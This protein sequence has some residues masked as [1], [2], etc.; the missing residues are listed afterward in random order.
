MEAKPQGKDRRLCDE[1]LKLTLDG[2]KKCKRIDGNKVVYDHETNTLFCPSLG[3][4]PYGG[5]HPAT[6]FSCN[7]NPK[8][9]WL[10]NRNTKARGKHYL[11]IQK[12]RDR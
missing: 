5:I 9:K 12:R 7:Y 6:C 11:N 3:T 2:A 1:D 8:N 4:E 10:M